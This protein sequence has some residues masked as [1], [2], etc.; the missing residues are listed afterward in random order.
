M[1][2][3]FC[4]HCETELDAATSICPACRWDPLT[5][6]S[7]PEPEQTGSLIDRYRGTEYDIAV[8]EAMSAP[9][10]TGRTSSNRVR[11]LVIAGIIALMGLYGSMMVY[12]DYEA[13]QDRP[14]VLNGAQR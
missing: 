4:P 5:A 11:T 8:F 6:D 12:H 1:N 7:S 3:Q 9:P 14:A 2:W 10:T 13:R